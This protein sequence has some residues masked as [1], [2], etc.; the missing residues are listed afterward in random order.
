MPQYVMAAQ[1]SGTRNGVDWPRRGAS[2]PAD[3]TADELDHMLAIG[4]VHEV[5][6]VIESAP[7]VEVS[8]PVAPEVRARARRTRGVKSDTGAGSV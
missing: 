8:R 7:V 6:P 1:I 5:K 2:A 4:H 3:L